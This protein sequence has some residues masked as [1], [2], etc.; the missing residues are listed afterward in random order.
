MSDPKD[1]AFSEEQF[2]K[3]YPLGVERHYWSR[4]RNKVIAHTLRKVN[5]VGPMLEI[6]CGKGVVVEYLRNDGFDIIGIELAPVKAL[7]SIAS[8]VDT[9]ADVLDMDPSVCATIRTILLL[10][11]IEHIEDPV[12]FLAMVRKKL[13]NAN[14]V[15]ATVPARQELFSNFDRFNNHFRRYD[16]D[17]LTDHLRTSDTRSS[18]VSYVFHGLYPAARLLLKSKGEREVGFNVPRNW[19]AE[20]FHFVLGFFFYVEFLVLPRKWKGTSVI[21][22]AK[23]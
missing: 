15:L 5:A 1:T 16:L 19:L 9:G 18:Y 14:C 22:V 8:F 23:S 7:P 17:M 6:G 10:D 2:D 13:P 12:A 3:L 20:V 11:V 21:G 4:C